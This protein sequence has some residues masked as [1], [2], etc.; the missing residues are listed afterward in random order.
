MRFDI[1][2]KSLFLLLLVLSNCAYRFSNL[3]IVR[4]GNIRSLAVE[5]VYDTSKMPIPHE[6]L[7]S[8]LQQ[9]VAANGHLQ[10]VSAGE[11]DAILRVHIQNAATRSSG[12]TTSSYQDVEEPVIPSSGTEPLG[13]SNFKDLTTARAFYPKATNFLTARAE[14]WHLASKELLLDRVY[15][16]SQ[17]FDAVRTGIVGVNNNF[18][19]FHE[20]QAQSFN[21]ISKDLATK[22]VDDLLVR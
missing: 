14:V 8:N 22:I 20:T 13:F 11:A 16:L 3:H 10:L 15:V 7:W 1:S 9:A 18:P 4:P 17:E 12:V 19:R 21:Q 5:A 2:N 6:V